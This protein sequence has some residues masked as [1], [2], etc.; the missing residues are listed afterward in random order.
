MEVLILQHYGCQN[1]RGRATRDVVGSSYE[2]ATG[3]P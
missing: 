2:E 3:A 1:G